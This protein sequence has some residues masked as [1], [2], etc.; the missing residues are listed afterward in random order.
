MGEVI[1]AI[2][3]PDRATAVA[4]AHEL[5]DQHAGEATG[6]TGLEVHV[7]PPEAS[8]T[9][10]EVYQVPPRGCRPSAP[11]RPQGRRPDRAD[12]AAGGGGRLH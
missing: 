8:L 1:E 11:A 12:Q 10:P 6:R 3:A 5:L 4:I 9:D 2:D 7:R